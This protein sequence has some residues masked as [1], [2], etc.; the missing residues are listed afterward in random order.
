MA[1]MTEQQRQERIKET[2]LMTGVTRSEAEFILAQEQG[3]IE[4][5]V[6][7]KDEADELDDN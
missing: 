6:L 2:M 3:E 5:D 7:T 4:S 1:E